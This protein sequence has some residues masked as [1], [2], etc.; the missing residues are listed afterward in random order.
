MAWLIDW[1]L[2]I[3]LFGMVLILVAFILN[4]FT[5][6]DS[7]DNSFLL[8]NLVGS[9]AMVVYAMFI[10]SIPSFILNGVW[11]CS[12]AWGLIHHA[13]KKKNAGKNSTKKIST[14]GGE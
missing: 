2:F 5:K 3:G 12:A 1:T 10:G 8:M 14:R 13:R 6:I 4:V 9:L 11:A 7:S